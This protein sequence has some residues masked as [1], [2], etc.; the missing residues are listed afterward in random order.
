[1]DNMLLIEEDH[2]D[3]LDKLV[4]DFEKFMFGKTKLIEVRTASQG[5]SQ[6]I[7][8]TQGEVTRTINSN[9]QVKNKYNKL[10]I[11]IGKSFRDQIKG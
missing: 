11:G 3:K 6:S 5:V 8:I 7:P 10:I 4:G 1:M 2:Y 9:R